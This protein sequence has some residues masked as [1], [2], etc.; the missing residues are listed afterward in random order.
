MPDKF[1]TIVSPDGRRGEVPEENLAKALARGYKLADAVP[2]PVDVSESSAPEM[3]AEAPPVAPESAPVDPEPRVA[4]VSP[5]GRRATVPAA[6]LQAALDRGYLT[7]EQAEAEAQYGDQ[8]ARTFA[9]GL[10]RGATLGLSDVVQAEG[11]GLGTRLGNYA[12]DVM[13]LGETHRA[14]ARGVHAPVV[15]MNRDEQAEQAVLEA[16]A[17][18]QGR[19]EANP[20]AAGA[21]EVGG[22]VLTSVA[23]GGA[24]GLGAAA[25][26]R[27]AGQGLLATLKRKGAELAVQGAAEGAVFGAAKELNDA[28]L[29]G[30]Y[31]SIA[32]RALIGAAEGGAIGGVAAPLVGGVLH[33]AG[34]LIRRIASVGD[35]VADDVAKATSEASTQAD[36][37]TSAKVAQDLELENQIVQQVDE[38]SKLETQLAGDATAEVELAF[39]PIYARQ[40][41]LVSSD[42]AEAEIGRIAK[43]A[44][45]ARAAAGGFENAHQEAVKKAGDAMDEFL[46]ISDYM[47][48]RVSKAAKRAKASEL[49]ALSEGRAFNSPETEAVLSAFE[50]EIDDL[51]SYGAEL[52]QG[53]AAAVKLIKTKLAGTRERLAKAMQ[54]GRVGD[55]ASVLDDFKSEAD[56]IAARQR[57]PFVADALQGDGQ[58][59]GAVD[60]LRK[61]LED[62]AIFG[63]YG[64]NQRVVNTAWAESIRRSRD[65]MLRG[66]NYEGGEAAANPFRLLAKVNRERLGS[67]LD[68][69]GGPRYE[70]Y[71]PREIAIRKWLRSA[72]IDAVTR[73]RTWGGPKAQEMAAQMKAL[74]ETIES[75]IDLVA[76][77]RR[78]AEAWKALVAEAD[79]IQILGTKATGALKVAQNAISKYDAVTKRGS[80]LRSTS[81]TSAA[82]EA[83]AGASVSTFQRARAA[84]I[85]A[86]KRIVAAP[87]KFIT[88]VTEGTPAASGG[89]RA[90]TFSSVR[91]MLDE[92]TQLQDPTSAVSQGLQASLMDLERD[93]PKMAMAMLAKVQTRAQFITQKATELGDSPQGQMALVR[94]AAAVTDP[95]GAL[96]R[97]ADG[98][99][100]PEDIETLQTVYPALWGEFVAKAVEG[101]QGKGTLSERV[102]AS[103]KLGVAVDPMLSPENLAFTQ[104]RMGASDAAAAKAK[105][106]DMSASTAPLAGDRVAFGR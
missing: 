70:N 27:I 58:R 47:R 96:E 105:A 30:D 15:P 32:T 103:L 91:Q 100:S 87:A 74:R 39:E 34:K 95:A 62:E 17:D 33:G 3:A 99:D 1:I 92:A 35:D 79:G 102:R 52:D 85:K 56:R 63:E 53:G 65:E 42:V 72:E 80:I 49:N 94:Y 51:A 68:Q 31:D 9:E 82:T 26:K 36:V 97:I 76:L 93:D 8:N 6:N 21:G 2:E 12:A 37:K 50:A 77:A 54:E 55:A 84:A 73:A 98:T 69:F 81:K 59:P 45:E 24:S 90:I 28:Y 13:G 71:K 89:T 11:A 75:N 10:G 67:M 78:D 7:Q 66:L 64:R 86:N 61:H 46:R 60:L 29:A 106:M 48:T 41:A 22:A 43:A 4:V 25:G 88:R 20:Y 40:G 38:A 19:K 16:K 101:M 57:N 44:K 23:T 83:E 5:N 104:S 18:I 14:A